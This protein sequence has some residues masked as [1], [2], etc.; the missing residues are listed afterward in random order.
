[1]E[2]AWFKGEYLFLCP[3]VYFFEGPL[4]LTCGS[5]I[6]TYSPTCHRL[7][8]KG[9][10]F[11]VLGGQSRIMGPVTVDLVCSGKHAIIFEHCLTASQIPKMCHN[12]KGKSRSITKRIGFGMFASLL[13]CMC[14][15]VFGNHDTCSPIF[16][17]AVLNEP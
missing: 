12:N 11:S 13:L 14:P 2:T 17:S 10:L 15:D 3:S 9:K 6:I 7:G 16:I 8:T 4:Y 1:M 5:N